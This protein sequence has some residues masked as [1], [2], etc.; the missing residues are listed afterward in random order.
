MIRRPPRSTLFPYTTLFRSQLQNF[1]TVFPFRCFDWKAEQRQRNASPFDRP[2]FPC[3]Q[4]S[5][6]SLMLE[7]MEKLK[8]F[9]SAFL[10]WTL[11]RA[12]SVVVSYRYLPALFFAA[13]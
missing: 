11:P 8:Q 2:A 1:R 6:R 3:T 4:P 9:F 10:I 13:D 7:R 5:S 12:E